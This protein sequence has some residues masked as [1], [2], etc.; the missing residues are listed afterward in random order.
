MTLRSSSLRPATDLSHV[1]PPDASPA[2]R[3]LTHETQHTSA[4]QSAFEGPR[5]SATRPPAASLHTSSTQPPRPAAQQTDTFEHGAQRDTPRRHASDGTRLWNQGDYADQRLGRSRYNVRQVGC[6]MVSSLM[7]MQHVTGREQN[8]RAMNGYLNA[9]NGYDRSG[10][11]NWDVAARAVPNVR[12]QAQPYS[13]QQLNRNVD[14]GTPTVLRMQ[15]QHG[16]RTHHHYIE[17]TRRVQDA[18]GVSRY[19]ANDPNGGH[20][21]ELRMR[22]GRLEG[23]PESYSAVTNRPMHVFT[24]TQ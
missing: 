21:I 8:P 5:T 13:E 17:V 10:N 19:Y 22:N 1:H 7:A 12:H 15:Y 23:G 6:A 14:A 3:S 16:G 18:Q 11:L 24:R 20:E 9:H 4:S 2:R